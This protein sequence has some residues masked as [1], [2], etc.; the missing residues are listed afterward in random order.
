MPGDLLPLAG[1][2]IPETVLQ[3][4]SALTTRRNFFVRRTGR[5]RLTRRRRSSHGRGPVLRQL[6]MTRFSLC[7]TRVECAVAFIDISGLAYSRN[8]QML[9]PLAGR[10]FACDLQC[11]GNS[12]RRRRIT[13]HGFG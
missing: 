3:T 1:T 6:G 2:Q 5:K 7:S 4:S 11:F 9:A 10:K 12:S 8:V 13:G